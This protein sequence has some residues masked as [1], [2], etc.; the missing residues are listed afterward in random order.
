MFPWTQFLKNQALLTIM[1]EIYMYENFSIKHIC[2]YLTTVNSFRSIR[3]SSRLGF[4]TVGEIVKQ[5]YQ[6]I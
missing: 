1:S 4:S 2:R 3:F 5:C 6:T